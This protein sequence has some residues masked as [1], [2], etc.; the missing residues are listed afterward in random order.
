[1]K[2]KI[3]L[4]FLL[5]LPMMFTSCL[6]DQD[7]VFNISAS[8]RLDN[9]LTETKKVLMSQE[10][11]IMDYYYGSDYAYGGTFFFMS[12]D[13]TSVNVQSAKNL[14]GEKSLYKMTTHNGPVIS[15]DTYN[16]VFHFLA[17]PNQTMPEGYEADFEFSIVSATS[18]LV[19]LR[20]LRTNNICYLRPFTGDKKAYADAVS[21]ME[22]NLIVSTINGKIGE[23]TIIGVVDLDSRSIQFTVENDLVEITQKTSFVYTDKGLRICLPV[24][25]NEKTIQ[26]FAFNESSITFECIEE[27]N[28]GIVLHGILPQGY[29]R[30]E[31]FAGDYYF[32]FVSIDE[33]NQ[34]VETPIKVTLVPYEDKT[35]YLMKGLNPQ[36]DVILNFN[37]STGTLRMNSQVVGEDA[38]NTIFYH[39]C[40]YDA[41]TGYFTGPWTSTSANYGM[42]T[43]LAIADDGKTVYNWVNIENEDGF[44][45]NS[46]VLLSYDGGSSVSLYSN[47]NW[48]FGG[49]TDILLYVLRLIKI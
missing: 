3:L 22:E 9:A 34:A 18:E 43:Q 17:V 35:A 7:D 48:Y 32:T 10:T 45:I 16:S 47:Q 42:M 49:S 21:L 29:V 4:A 40:S 30:F 28:K 15:F 26:D 12:F 19:T 38:G 31:D 41:S 5:A 14:D 46:Y 24:V 2:N 6:K 25:A 33:N 27:E 37:K 1:M 13:S 23:D 44:D 20:G 36:F 39:C 11:W 8:D